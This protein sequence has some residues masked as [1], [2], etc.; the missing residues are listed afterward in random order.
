MWD[1]NIFLLISVSC[2]G[3]RTT[4]E[5]IY[6]YWFPIGLATASHEDDA[7]WF[8]IFP[9]D[10]EE[11]VYGRWEDNI[12]WDDQAMDRMLSPPVL[13]LDPND[14]N[15]I[16]GT[17]PFLVNCVSTICQLVSTYYE[18]SWSVTFW[19]LWS[20][21]K[22]LNLASCR[23]PRWE[24]VWAYVPLPVQGEQ[25]GV[26]TEEESHPAGE[27]WGHKGGASTGTTGLKQRT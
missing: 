7:P 21:H 18:I 25:E 16:L 26:G 24:G 2:H 20:I 8:S 1:Y 11:L 14:E 23:N 12:I 4:K 19:M 3:E 13:T 22:S 27:D 6:H 15:I 10:N 9:I 5:Y 17:A